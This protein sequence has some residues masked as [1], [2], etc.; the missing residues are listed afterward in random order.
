MKTYRIIVLGASGSGKTFFLASMYKKLCIQNKEIGFFL[1]AVPE[2]RRE[3]INKYS[4]IADPELDWPPG[5][6]RKDVSE[7][8]FLCRIQAPSQESYSAFELVYYDYSGEILTESMQ[9]ANESAVKVD[10]AIQQADAFLVLIDGQKVLH[11]LQDRPNA[12]SRLDYDL[13]HILPIVQGSNAVPLHFVVTKWDLLQNYGVDLSTVREQLEKFDQFSNIVNQRSGLEMP[14]RL[15]PISSLGPKFAELGPDGLLHKNKHEAPY[16][17]QVE[18]PLACTLLDKFQITQSQLTNLEGSPQYLLKLIGIQ[19]LILAAKLMGLL[20]IQ[21][22][23]VPVV[24]ALGELMMGGLQRQEHELAR[25]QETF[26]NE[27]KNKNSAI[28]SVIKSHN[29]LMAK[30]ETAFPDSVL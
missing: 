1:E 22:A 10:S 15:I 24:G 6:L 11:L 18:M 27:V 16:P 29:R 25:Q 8:R 7:W 19:L 3:L 5:T 17:F 21:A 2:Q 14:T 30:L 26:L 4:E 12:I 20:S 28:R 23:W 9:G 13:S